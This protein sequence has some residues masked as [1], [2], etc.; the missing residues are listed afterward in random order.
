MWG[1]RFSCFER[2]G[3]VFDF[4]CSAGWCYVWAGFWD[5][6]EGHLVDVSDELGRLADD[7]ESA[8]VGG[9]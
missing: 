2:F 1:T 6:D 4:Y 3:G 8:G 5:G 7:A 9:G